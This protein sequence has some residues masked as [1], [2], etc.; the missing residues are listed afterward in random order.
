MFFFNYILKLVT[1]YIH[2]HA[3]HKH[4]EKKERRKKKKTKAWERSKQ[5]LKKFNG[6]KICFEQQVRFFLKVYKTKKLECNY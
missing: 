3:L 6:S 4:K 2:L 1:F 5:K